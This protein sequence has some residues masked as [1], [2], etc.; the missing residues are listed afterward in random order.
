MT[1]DAEIRKALAYP[2]T[3]TNFAVHE[4]VGALVS[5]LVEWT[6]TLSR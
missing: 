6:R 3:G 1:T 5:A 2:L 4:R